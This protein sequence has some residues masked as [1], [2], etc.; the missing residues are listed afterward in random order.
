MYAFRRTLRR[1][2]D[3]RLLGYLDRCASINIGHWRRRIYLNVVF[4]FDLLNPC[5][6]IENEIQRPGR[7][8]RINAF[9]IV[10]YDR[11]DY[12]QHEPMNSIARMFNYFSDL[13]E[14]TLEKSIFVLHIL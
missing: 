12:G 9:L 8:F 14:R 11:T 13:Y 2:R 7:V 6:I 4:V 5:F 3:Y 10:D 1:A